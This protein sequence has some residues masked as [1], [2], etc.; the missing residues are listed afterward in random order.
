MN[1]CAEQ[2]RRIPAIL[3]GPSR[4]GSNSMA[5][6]FVQPRNTID[7]I[8]PGPGG[9]F[10]GVPLLPGNLFG[11][12]EIPAAPGQT[13]ALNLVGVHRVPK[14]SGASQPGALA[15]WPTTAGN[16][17]GTGAIGVAVEHADTDVVT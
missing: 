15:Y 5:R 14:G 4:D 6:T 13:F 16:V 1:D 9:I 17:T 12:P 3:P 7:A 8:A 2:E 10:T 11:I